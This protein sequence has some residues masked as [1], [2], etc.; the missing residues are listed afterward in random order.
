[1]L[2]CLPTHMVRQR[3][4]DKRTPHVSL[5]LPSL[6]RSQTSVLSPENLLRNQ[7]G[8]HTENVIVGPGAL[9]L[10]IVRSDAVPSHQNGPSLGSE[11]MSVI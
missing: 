10:R 4:P 5:H 2:R 11:D 9:M 6:R 1:M 8:S 3:S 7:R